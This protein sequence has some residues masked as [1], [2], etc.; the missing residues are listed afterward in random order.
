MGDAM[1]IAAAAG[2]RSNLELTIPLFVIP[3]VLLLLWHDIAS[4]L[5][6]RVQEDAVAAEFDEATSLDDETWL[7][8]FSEPPLRLVS[9][10]RPKGVVERRPEDR[11]RARRERDEARRSRQRMEGTVS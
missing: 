6:R 11:E 9:D 7:D 3:I 5:E 8:C 2:V 4:H 10:P 1:L